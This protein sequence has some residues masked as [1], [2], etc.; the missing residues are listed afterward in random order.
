MECNIEPRTTYFSSHFKVEKSD[1]DDWFDPILGTDTKFFVDPFLIFQDDDPIWRTAHDRLIDH[2]NI[3]FKL[4]AEGNRNPDSVPYRKAI[5]LLR[6]P[7]PR[8]FCLGYTETGTSGLGGGLVYAQLI[9]V[10]MEEAITRGL[11]DLRHFEELGVLN[12]GIGPDRIS[13][14]AC[15]V[16]RSYFI[17]YTRKVV[18]RHRIATARV[19]VGGAAFDSRRIAWKSETLELP[20]NPLND[21]PVLLVPERFLRD[22]PVLNA[23]DWWENYEAEQLRNDMNYE[24]LGRVSKKVIVAAARRHPDLVREWTKNKEGEKARPYDLSRDPLGRWQWLRAGVEFVES[25]PLVIVPPTHQAEFVAVIELVIGKYKTYVEEQGGWK[26]LWNDDGTEKPEEAAQLLFKGIAKA[27]CEAN[28]IV[29]DREV[30]LG[31][32]PIDFKFSNGFRHRALLEV[33][34]LHNGRF[35]N[36]LQQ[37]LPSYLKSDECSL[38]WF[39][40]VQYREGGASKAW[41]KAGPAIVK[42]VAEDNDLTLKTVHVDCRAKP[43]ASKIR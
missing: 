43:S 22:L 14:L 25:Q 36:G 10:A 21:S 30:E 29:L 31:R 35:W 32:G 12:E 11:T 1:D 41:A 40:V 4:I 6:F 18:E 38:G 42:K 33:K 2:F 19:K 9:A 5:G 26:L 24:V 3:C 39:V 37:Q 17:E 7:E 8:E 34:K 16:L 23:D 13:D 15:N 27:Y 28:N 20:I